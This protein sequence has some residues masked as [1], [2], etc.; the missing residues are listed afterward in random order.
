MKISPWWLLAL[1]VPVLL[2]GELLVRRVRWLAR[3]DL[4]VPVV[5]GFVVAL[6]VLTLN[7]F[8]ALP[9]TMETRTAARW[10]TWLVTALPDWRAKPPPS[11]AVFLPFSTAFFTCVGLNA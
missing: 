11:V 1:A 6:I 9:I 7:V 4:P 5:G 3:F 2:L 8:D 10:W